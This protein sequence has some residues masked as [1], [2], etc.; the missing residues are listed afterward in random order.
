MDVSESETDMDLE[1]RRICDQDLKFGRSEM[2]MKMEMKNAC[3][4]E[5]GIVVRGWAPKEGN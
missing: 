3:L 4:H 2:K 1:F 5:N